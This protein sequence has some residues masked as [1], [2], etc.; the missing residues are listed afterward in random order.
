MI[1]VTENKYADKCV[2][3]MIDKNADEHGFKG[4]YLV[5]TDNEFTLI[6]VVGEGDM[7]YRIGGHGQHWTHNYPQNLE[8][9]YGTVTFESNSDGSI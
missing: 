8:P 2:R 5:S 4:I 3:L 6:S 7:T 9:Y 1:I